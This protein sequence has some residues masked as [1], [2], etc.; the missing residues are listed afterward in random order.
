MGK[1]NGTNRNGTLR[2]AG[3]ALDKPGILHDIE[4][5]D[6]FVTPA[7]VFDADPGKAGHSS[8]SSR[9]RD[10]QSSQS[11]GRLVRTERHRIRPIAGDSILPNPT[12]IE[13][14][15][16]TPTNGPAAGRDPRG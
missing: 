7:A 4:E 3:V 9:H 1:H 16:K 13:G 14:G 10:P 12:M 15:S 11:A 2:R 6:P 8:I 5:S